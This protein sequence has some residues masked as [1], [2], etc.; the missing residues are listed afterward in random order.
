VFA[1]LLQHVLI[2]LAATISIVLG[3]V[4]G[5]SVGFLSHRFERRA[6]AWVVLTIALVFAGGLVQRM[7]LAVAVLVGFGALMVAFG[8]WL[9]SAGAAGTG[10]V[11]AIIGIVYVL[12]LG[13]S[14]YRW[15]KRS[16]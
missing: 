2:W 7:P 11:Y 14:T 5:Q 3:A 4:S 12:T 10:L 8:G 1:R 15:L 6:L 16:N 13:P 9:A